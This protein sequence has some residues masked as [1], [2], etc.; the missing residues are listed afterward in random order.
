YHGLTNKGVPQYDK[1]FQY[2]SYGVLDGIDESIYM[3]ADMLIHG[4]GTA[5]NIDMGLNLLVD[6]YRNAQFDFCHGN[7]DCRFAEYAQHMG[8]CCLEGIIY[9][10]GVKD[11][12]RFFL[13][14]EYAAKL[15]EKTEHPVGEEFKDKV[16]SALKNIRES[17]GL[18]LSRTEL[19][20]DF[21]IFISQIYEDRYPVR[22]SI[23]QKKD[24]S[25]I[26]L[27]VGKF[28]LKELF[29]SM[30]LSLNLDDGENDSDDA[31]S[32]AGRLL[33]TYPELS[34]SGLVS[35]MEYRLENGT[36]LKQP[37]KPGPFLS[38]G[39]RREDMTNVLEFYAHGEVIAAVEAE[40][41]IVS[42]KKDEKTD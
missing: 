20:A 21:P 16:N 11:A 42:V 41:Y 7:Y 32:L 6:G 14:A 22:V 35:E 26:F 28:D 40:W 12:Y 4:E 1:A 9:G 25:D 19:K 3:A 24:S 10:M 8:D 34:W 30:K 5:K 23:T 29:Q 27:K 13:E 17:I 18:D 33:V 38:D 39:F 2:F 37:E 31:Q 15:R 36:I